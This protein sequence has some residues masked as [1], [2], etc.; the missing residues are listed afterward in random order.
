M[1]LDRL[2]QL[3]LL[4][5]DEGA[6]APADWAALAWRILAPQGQRLQH[7]GRVLESDEENIALLKARAGNFA[8]RRLPVLR[9]LGVAPEP[10]QAPAAQ[11]ASAVA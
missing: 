8:A 2:E 1:A 5:L 4:A 3:F 9:S 6:Q 11:R 7:E 10:Q